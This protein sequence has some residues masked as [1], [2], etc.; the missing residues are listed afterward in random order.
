MSQ[1][2]RPKSSCETQVSTT[3]SSSREWFMAVAITCWITSAIH[4][5]LFPFLRAL[6]CGKSP[7]VLSRLRILRQPG[8]SR[9]RRFGR[10]YLIPFLSECTIYA[11][12]LKRVDKPEP[13]ASSVDFLAGEAPENHVGFDPS[14]PLLGSSD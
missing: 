6:D 14:N 9:M 10:D 7:C 13:V 4:C 5:T 12:M 3:Q 2:G 11:V 1:S 8:S